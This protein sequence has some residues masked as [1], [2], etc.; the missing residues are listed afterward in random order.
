VDLSLFYF[1]DDGSA[2]T[3]RYRLLIEGARFAD[4]HGF[5]AVWTPERHFHSFGG[6]YPN[7]AVTSAAVATITERISIR[8]GSVVAPLHHAVRIAE[9]W[10]VVDNLSGG[11]A[12]I[13]FASGWNAVDFSLRPENYIDRKRAQADTIEMVRRLWRGEEVELTDGTGAPARVRIYPVPV[14]SDLPIWLTSTG[15]LATFRQAGE[16][17]VGVLTHLIW[18][19]LDE[20]AEKISI[21]RQAFRARDGAEK[22]GHIV[23]MAHTFLGADREKVREIVRQPFSNYLRSSIGLITSASG[24]ALSDIKHEDVNPE[25]V[26]FLVARSFDRYFETGGLFGT[27]EDGM[28]MLTRLNEVGVDEVAC[29]IDFVSD[30]DAVL[31]SL[32]YLEKLR[33]A[34]LDAVAE[35]TRS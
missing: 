5:S 2:N 10:A 13:S 12:G 22:C 8:A 1:A 7:P 34:S 15:N 11:R 25:D 6:R 35:G 18:Q 4:S 32:D 20:L 19:D 9:E 16:L 28:R 3:D 26:D 14:Q 17:G 23:L 29:L 31:G 21:Y 27:V 30:T 33:L 24:G